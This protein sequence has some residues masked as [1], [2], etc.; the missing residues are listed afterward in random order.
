MTLQRSQVRALS[1]PPKKYNKQSGRSFPTRGR[2]SDTEVVGTICQMYFV[3]ILQSLKNGK[4]YV[5]STENLV[6]RL[7]Q[8]NL[9]NVKFTRSLK[10]LELVFSQKYSTK[11]EARKIE[12]R[13]KKLKRRDYLEKI[14][15]D[16]VLTLRT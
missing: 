12:F 6:R 14:I 13:I 8:H 3:Y 1:G 10:P 11:E 15:K 16:K 2:D 4:Y 7:S 9:G 5:G